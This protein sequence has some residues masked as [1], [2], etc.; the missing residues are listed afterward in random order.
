[1]NFREDIRNP[2]KAKAINKIPNSNSVIKYLAKM[3]N[4]SETMK[5]YLLYSSYVKSNPYIFGNF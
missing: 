3:K 2:I 1:M 4:S 5:K